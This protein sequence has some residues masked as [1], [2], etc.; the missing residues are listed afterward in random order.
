MNVH[1]I[2]TPGRHPEYTFINEHLVE[3]EQ[4]VRFCLSGGGQLISISGPS[5]SGKTVFVE[6]VL[7]KDHILTISGSAVRT[8]DDVWL[9]VLALIGTPIKQA[10]SH[11]ATTGCT[12]NRA[13]GGEVNAF[14]IKISANAGTAD[15][16]VED[17][18]MSSLYSSSLLDLIVNDLAETPYVIF[19]DDFHYIAKE[20]QSRLAKQIK[21]LVRRRVKIIC[22]TVPYHSD[23]VLRANTDLQGRILSIDFEY[24]QKDTLRLIAEKGCNSLNICLPKE[25]IDR[26]A[27]ESSGSPQ[28]M[29]SLCLSTCYVSGIIG[30]GAELQSLEISEE[31]FKKACDQTALTT[32]YRSL[33]SQMLEGPKVR[34]SDRK[35]YRTKETDSLDV[36]GIVLRAL[37]LAPP[38]LTIRY[39]DLQGR[40]EQI[41][42]SEQPTGSSITSTCNQISLIAQK[43]IEWDGNTDV[44]DIRDPYLLFYMRWGRPK[45]LSDGK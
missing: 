12:A 19:I 40:I 38:S 13:L 27:N 39:S 28:L 20:I 24:W 42:E 34:G 25:Y 17:E 5:K 8:E 1:D 16:K 30:V 37:T 15:S 36:Y 32:D 33:Y 10:V 2:F 44:L 18:T 7:G 31:Q 45:L 21:E 29:Q 4:L 26:I 3:K 35:S 22:A 41:C 43:A 14:G 6:S 9:C 11:T 23:D